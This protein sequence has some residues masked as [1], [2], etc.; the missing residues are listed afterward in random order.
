MAECDVGQRASKRRGALN[1]RAPALL[2][3]RLRG[4][5]YSEEQR[6]AVR[7]T[8]WVAVIAERG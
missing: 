4:C 6:S 7:T 3:L 5:S 1:S 8:A 2:T